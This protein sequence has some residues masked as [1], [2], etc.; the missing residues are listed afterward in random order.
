MNIIEQKLEEL[1][2][3][4]EIAQVL[5]ERRINELNDM[6]LDRFIEIQKSQ[7]TNKNK[8]REWGKFVKDFC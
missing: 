1:S 7:A 2:R 6:I 5:E 3:E 4:E 8:E